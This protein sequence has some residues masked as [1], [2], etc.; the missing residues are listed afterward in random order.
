MLQGL[1]KYYQNNY[2]AILAIV[3]LTFLVWGKIL[4]QVFLGEGYMYFDR[5]PTRSFFT[6]NTFHD[7]SFIRYYDNFARILFDIIPHFFQDNI[8]AYLFLELI[9]MII[10]Y[11]SIYGVITKVTKSKLVGFSTAVFFL[12]NYVGSFFLLAEGNFQRFLQRVPNFIPAIFAFYFLFKYYEF[13]KRRDYISSLA[14]YS[15]ALFLGHFSSIILP[16]FV[17]YPIV[18]LLQEKKAKKVFLTSILTV[19]PFLLLTYF[20]TTSTVDQSPTKGFPQ[21]ILTEPDLLKKVL[22]QI[23]L[24]TIP[25]N[26]ILVIA[27]NTRLGILSEPYT[28]IVPVL[29]L[30]CLV[31]YFFGGIIILKK[32]KNLLVLYLTSFLSMVGSMLLYVYVDSRLD[33][34]KYFGADRFFLIPTLLATI[35]WAILLKILFIQK[36]VFYKFIAVFILVYFVFFNTQLIWTKIDSIQYKSEMLKS[37]LKYVKANSSQFNSQTIIIVPSYLQWPVILITDYGSHPGVKAEVE[38]DGWENKYWN[39]RENVYVYDYQ[40]D[41]GV[42]KTIHPLAGHVVDFTEKYRRGEKIH[43]LN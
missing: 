3:L 25:L 27:Q 22:Y 5:Q 2:L 18:H 19:I 26:L 41:R 8:Q 37:F 12:A 9:L 10:L 11:L 17:L 40:F 31:F 30:I 33:M 32:Q 15:L 28:E 1:I 13:K 36:Q 14:F 42:D 29:T 20:V 6:Y 21:F 34:L 43:F 23:P 38:F 16:L 39:N 7:F 35:C 24:I 4:N